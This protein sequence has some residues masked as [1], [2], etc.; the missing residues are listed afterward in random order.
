[1][2]LS[3]GECSV[4]PDPQLSF[5]F[6]G[7]VFLIDYCPMWP[8]RWTTLTIELDA[9]QLSLPFPRAPTEKDQT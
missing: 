9:P 6:M 4:V 7:D 5:P 2:K 8:V 1:M 3:P